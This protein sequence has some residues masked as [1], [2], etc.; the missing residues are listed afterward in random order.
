VALGGILRDVFGSMASHGLF[1]HA[2]TGPATGYVF[3]YALEIVLLMATVVAM[4]PL[5]RSRGEAAG[6]PTL[7][8]LP[9]AAK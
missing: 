9:V 4:L 3:V 2:L 7:D 1:G 8:N 6:A 5:M